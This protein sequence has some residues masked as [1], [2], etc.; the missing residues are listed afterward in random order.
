MKI[1]IKDEI[2]NLQARVWQTE[3]LFLVNREHL[4]D[5]SWGAAF[6]LKCD[7]VGT[8]EFGLRGGAGVG[9]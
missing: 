9:T 6:S 2:L 3:I 7:A 1:T 8:V 4:Q 5:N